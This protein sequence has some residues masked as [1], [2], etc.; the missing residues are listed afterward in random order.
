MNIFNVVLVVSLSTVAACGATDDS[1]SDSNAAI[2][3]DPVTGTTPLQCDELSVEQCL[4]GPD[5]GH[6]QGREILDKNGTPCIDW[7]QEP[8][9][10]GCLSNNVGCDDALTYAAP[11]DDPSDCWLFTNGCIPVGWGYCDDPTPV[12][13]CDGL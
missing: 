8:V 4:D 2:T 3:S 7:S 10:K 9:A 11:N 6:I 12:E 5:C 13:E 1:A